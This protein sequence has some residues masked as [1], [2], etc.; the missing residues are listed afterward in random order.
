MEE[1]RLAGYTKQLDATGLSC[2]LPIL[3]TKRA[4]NKLESGQVLR[5]IASDPGTVKNINA[6]I[7]Q[8][9]DEL[10]EA[11]TRGRIFIYRI[12]KS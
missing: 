2:P 10:L 7:N 6:Y 3:R 11:T 8:S 5:V 9:G 4:L 12:K 1:N